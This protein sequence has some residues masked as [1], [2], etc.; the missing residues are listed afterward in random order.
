LIRAFTIFNW[1]RKHCDSRQTLIDKVVYMYYYSS[2]KKKT[3][4]SVSP[5]LLKLIDALPE[6]PTRSQII[7]EALVLYFKDIKSRQRDKA[8]ISILNDVSKAYNAEALDALE[9]QNEE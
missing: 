4:I 8:D 2:M 7:E 6:K 3:S 5:K 9:Y 1:S